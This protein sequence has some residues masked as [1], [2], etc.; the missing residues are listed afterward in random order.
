MSSRKAILAFSAVVAFGVLA[1]A[2]AGGEKV[3]FPE[4]F[5]KG[6]LYA[7]VDRHDIKQFRELY[8]SP[9]V[10]EAVRN[11]QPVPGG[12]VLTLVQYRAKVDDKGT[13]VRGPDGR[14]VK[15]ALLAYTVMEKRAGWGT[16]YP[17]NIRNGEW[18]YQAFTADKKVNPKANLTACFQCH[19]PHEKQDF[20]ISLASLSGAASGRT[21]T[22]RSG[23][24]IVSIAEFLFGPEKTTVKVGD[25]ITWTNADDSPHQVTVQGETTLRTPVLLKGQS[26]TILFKDL[27]SYDYICG[28]HPNMKG[29]IE[30]TR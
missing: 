12:A 25:S 9:G 14:F 22:K 3:A 24:G 27:G 8:A 18:E 26:T 30:V 13:P 21:A 28:L 2:R 5:E 15:D 7:T 1:Q 17:A 4:G 29:K 11:G 23:P 10:V 16:E 6:T 19:K 20:V